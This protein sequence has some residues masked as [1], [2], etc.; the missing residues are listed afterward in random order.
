[1]L[2]FPILVRFLQEN[3][4]LDKIQGINGNGNLQLSV[5]AENSQAVDLRAAFSLEAAGLNP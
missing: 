5:S 3:Q 4:I 1:M 2:K